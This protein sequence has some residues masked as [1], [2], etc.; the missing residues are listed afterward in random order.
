VRAPAGAL[1]LGADYRGLGVVRSLGRRGVRVRVLTHPGETLAA[2]SRYAE[3]ALR[4]PADLLALADELPGWALIPTT[5]ED[6]AAVA[7]RHEVLGRVFTLTTPPWE[8]LQWA[9]DKRCTHLLADETGV[10]RPWTAQP[11]TVDELAALDPPFP[12][13]LKPAIKTAHN[14]LTAAKAW[15]VDTKAE[16]VARWREAVELVPV[17]VLLVQE[18]VPGDGTSQYSYAALW[19]N[20]RPLAAVAARRTRQYPA[21]FGRASTFVETVDAPEAAE[22]AQ[23]LVGR[24][25][26]TGLA[27]VEFKRDAR[28]GTMKVLD[29]NPRVWG[30]HTLGAR[31][32]VDFP[33]LLW[34]QACGDTIEPVEG[35]A[36]ERWLRLT[37]DLPTGVR[38]VLARRLPL[39][40]YVSSLVGRR[41]RAIAARDDVLPGLLEVPLLASLLVRRLA[42]GAG[43]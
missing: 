43:V 18:L 9:Y 14:R 5:D 12:C 31:A 16:L 21:D 19:E 20:G 29:V 26:L 35:R 32:G 23:R 37:T 10:P 4:A 30:W 2:H 25:G 39:R 7:R 24:I 8:T 11:R 3:R 6:A 27:E 15:R 41:E 38:E 22:L 36:G 42:G 1:V 40:P 13:V 17:D 28:D 34:R 33:W